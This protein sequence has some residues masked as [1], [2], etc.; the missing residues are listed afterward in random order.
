[1]KISDILSIILVGL[2]I[3]VLGRLVL[4]GRQQ[5]GVF[6]TFVVGM[7]AAVI[8]YFAARALGIGH[9]QPA[10]V[11]KFHW[12][13]W[14][15]LIQVVLAV[16]FVAIANEMTYTRLADGGTRSRSTRRKSRS[17]ST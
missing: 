14:V 5:I 15:L 6:T 12:D 17:R 1:M 7:A 8:G 11:W 10:H 16:I 2:I 3:G 13:W 4:P 9:H